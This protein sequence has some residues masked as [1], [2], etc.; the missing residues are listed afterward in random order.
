MTCAAAGA[1][2]SPRSWVVH[3]RGVASDMP[4]NL[5]LRRGARGSRDRGRGAGDGGRNWTAASS[6]RSASPAASSTQ[7]D[8]SI[9]TGRGRAAGDR[10][11][12]QRPLRPRHRPG[13]GLPRGG[14]RRHFPR[15]PARRAAVGPRTAAAV[16]AHGTRSGPPWPRPSSTGSAS[17]WP[18]SPGTTTPSTMPW[19]GCP[20]SACRRS[21]S[22]GRRPGA[23]AP[24]SSWWRRAIPHGS[25]RRSAPRASA[26]GFLGGRGRHQCS[27]VLELAVPVPR[28]GSVGNQAAAARDRRGCC[29]A[30]S[31]C[32]WPPP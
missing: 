13:R 10:P 14:M 19:S 27:G 17:D 20:A 5:R 8:K 21:P 31:T 23:T 29:S 24:S 15:R 3:M 30:R 16:D 22:P 2:T 11:P 1:T 25:P 12:E 6:A 4:A 18:I 32:R 9:N 26:P 28:R 7:S